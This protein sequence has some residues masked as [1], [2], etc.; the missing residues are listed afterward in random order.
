MAAKMWLPQG[1]EQNK[2]HSSQTQFKQARQMSVK[3]HSFSQWG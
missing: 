1:P 2:Y 3:V